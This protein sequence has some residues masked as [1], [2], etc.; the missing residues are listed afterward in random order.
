MEMGDDSFPPIWLIN[1]KG[2][3]SQGE[4]LE[5]DHERNVDNFKGQPVLWKKVLGQKMGELFTDLFTVE[6]NV[7]HIYTYMLYTCLCQVSRYSMTV[8]NEMATAVFKA[9]C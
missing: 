8:Q 6:H 1:A 2:E 7:Y 3:F 9:H 4:L 5:S